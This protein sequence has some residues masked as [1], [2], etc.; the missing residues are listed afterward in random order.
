M[1]NPVLKKKILVVV[2]SLSRGGAERQAALMATMLHDSGYHVVILTLYND[3]IKYDFRA[4]KVVDLLSS[5]EGYKK[6]RKL[7]FIKMIRQVLLKEKPDLICSFLT[8]ITYL[9]SRANARLHIPQV[10]MVRNSYRHLSFLKKL[11]FHLYKNRITGLILQNKEQEAYYSRKLIN[12]SFILY[13][14]LDPDFV[15]VPFQT[16]AT[17]RNFVALGRLMP[18]KDYGLMIMAFKEALISNSH[19][20]LSIYGQG[21]LKTKLETLIKDQQLTAAI[22]IHSH[23]SNV[24]EVLLRHDAFLMT[25]VYEGFPNAMMEAMATGLPV[26]ATPFETGAITLLGHNERGTLVSRNPKEIAKA[27]LTYEANPTLASE[28]AKLA[29]EYINHVSNPIYV[30]QQLLKIITKIFGEFQGEKSNNY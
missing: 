16:R 15:N 14:S 28:K 7:A 25:S 8:F 2:P 20:K 29:Y 21:P 27:I 3:E 19:L 1:N 17:I 18:Q 11:M 12:K 13:N 6:T 10:D 24:K 30:K 22:T 26:I 9:T 23:V 5:Y 4:T